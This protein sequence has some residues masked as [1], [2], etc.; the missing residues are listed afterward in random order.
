MFRYLLAAAL[1]GLCPPALAGAQDQPEALQRS[2][3]QLRTVVGRWDVV[4]EFLNEDGSVARSVTG[5]YEFTWIVPD[6]VV[7]GRSEQPELKQAAGL[8]FYVNEAERKIEM[9]SVG[10][11]GKLWIMTGPLG[12]EERLSQE[13][14]TAGGGVGRLRFTR[15]NVS[16]DSFESRMEYTEDGGSTWKPGN[17]QVFRRA[18]AAVPC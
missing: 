8:L 5:T 17:H 7:A 11:D 16:P 1:A 13:F 15:F 2:V 10:G 4:T 9:V 18:A 3:E 14:P 12:E 6:R